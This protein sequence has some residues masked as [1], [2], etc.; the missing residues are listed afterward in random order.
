MRISPPPL[1]VTLLPPS[2]TSFVPL[3]LNTFAV[4]VITIVTGSGPQS[5][6]MIPPLATA[7]TKASPV[8]PAGEPDP[9]T[10]VGDDTSSAWPAGATVAW[11][12]GQPAGGPSW[13]FVGPPPVDVPPPVVVPPDEPDP[14]PFPL[15]VAPDPG[16]VGLTSP[17]HAPSEASTTRV[18][19]GKAKEPRS[20]L[21]R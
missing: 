19:A 1:R 16:A 13:G 12:S 7:A 10:V 18:A 9:I 4:D 6:V 2:M 21:P 20:I 8:H 15:D 17:L 3:S 14:P 11:P 5:N